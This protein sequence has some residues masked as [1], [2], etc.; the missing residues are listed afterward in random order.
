[1]RAELDEVAV[2]N[3]YERAQELFWRKQ[4]DYGPGNIAAFGEIG[5]IV[6]MSD[7][8]ER[9][10]RLVVEKREASNESIEDSY[11]DLLNYAAIALLVR[12][13]LWPGAK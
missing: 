8:I 10:K 7:K 13:G 11:L 4:E 2:M 3:V 1:M 12:R 6:R 9:L 5:C